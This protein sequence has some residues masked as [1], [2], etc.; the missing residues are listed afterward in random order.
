MAKA[1]P[2]KAVVPKGWKATWRTAEIALRANG[3]AGEMESLAPFD[4]GLRLTFPPD[5]IEPSWVGIADRLWAVT[6]LTCAECGRD[7]RERFVPADLRDPAH[8][9]T[10]DDIRALVGPSTPHFAL[11]TRNRVAALIEGLPADDPARIEGERHD[12]VF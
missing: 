10:T 7:G 8:R 2:A 5:R 9:L 12:C 1:R 3:W 4:G 6:R 11:Q